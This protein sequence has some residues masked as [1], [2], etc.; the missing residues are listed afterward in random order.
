MANR[1]KFDLFISY[2]N[3][4]KAEVNK[5]YEQLFELG[6]ISWISDEKGYLREIDE[7]ELFL[8]CATTSYNESERCQVELKYAYE[9]NKNIIFFFFENF[10]GE[11]DRNNKLK[12]I[13]SWFLENKKYYR[14]DRID[15]LI[16]TISELLERM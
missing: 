15:D 13:L 2:C 12:G 8:C 14:H 1:F 11:E 5:L 4:N 16:I 7:S 6:Y 10:N 9:Q 3:N